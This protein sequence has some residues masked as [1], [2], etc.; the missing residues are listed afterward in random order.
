[1]IA[2]NTSPDAGS[3]TTTVKCGARHGRQAQQVENACGIGSA[4][5]PQ[6]SHVGLML[7]DCF[8]DGRAI[9]EV[10][11]IGIGNDD[12]TI[13]HGSAG[14]SGCPVENQNPIMLR[15]PPPRP[16]ASSGQRFRG[17]E[18]ERQE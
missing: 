18:P 16:S 2:S 13:L 5:V 14:L 3:L 17:D 4:T 11:A 8:D 1:M 7:L 12:L 9:S 10:E 15:L 6:N